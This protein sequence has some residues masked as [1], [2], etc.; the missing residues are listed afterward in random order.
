MRVRYQLF[1]LFGFATPVK[2]EKEPR[3]K[4]SRYFLEVDRQPGRPTRNGKE[5]GETSAESKLAHKAV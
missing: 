4:N 2:K 1:S 5:E 3:T